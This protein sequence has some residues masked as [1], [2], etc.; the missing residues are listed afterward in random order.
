VL[1]DQ[2]PGA[3]WIVMAGP[4]GDEFCLEGWRPRGIQKQT[5]IGDTLRDVRRH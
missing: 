3:S 4:E 5:V 1:D 2:P